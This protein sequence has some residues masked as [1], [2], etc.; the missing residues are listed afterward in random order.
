V[1]A[2][3]KRA[4][5]TLAALALAG[6]GAL[7]YVA[8]NL[9]D[10]LQEELAAAV[11][12]HTGRTLAFEGA[13]S[14][15]FWPRL[16]LRFGPARLSEPGDAA[17]FAR[18]DGAR[19]AIAPLPL[20][21]RRVEVDALEVDGLAATLVRRPD[22]TLNIA[23]LLP[24]KTEKVGAGG[25]A[26]QAIDIARLRIAGSTLAW[27]DE[28]SG[29]GFALSGFELAGGP[30]RIAADRAEAAILRF[31]ADA[32][33]KDAQLRIAL[34]SPI[35]LD[36][37][38]RRLALPQLAGQ[39][40]LRHPR[41]VQPPLALPLAGAAQA[42]LAA[43]RARLQLESR[44]DA[45]RLEATAEI[46][47]FAPFALSVAVAIDQLDLDRYL[48]PDGRAAAGRLDLAFLESLD[49][50]GTLQIGRLKAGGFAADNVRLDLDAH[51]RG[52]TQE[53]NAG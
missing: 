46:G 18:L 48:L 15:D 43:Q 6:I 33:W 16:A 17:T 30:L 34:A 39:L 41:L 4:G 27:R 26:P 38:R 12:R 29:G 37:A 45:T 47:S 28:R 10:Y 20:L 44:F 9:G 25:T 52:Q 2:A 42:D 22:G 24:G 23:D 36:L 40:A 21:S 8:A 31:A 11:A 35:A 32:Q 14:V 1:K 3:L 7:A 49:L 53:R 19:I 50:K 13:P 51:A 5:G